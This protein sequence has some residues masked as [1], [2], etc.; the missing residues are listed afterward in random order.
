MAQT[1]WR[2]RCREVV[3]SSGLGYDFVCHVGDIAEFSG[4][5]VINYSE[6]NSL[7]GQVMR[8]GTVRKAEGRACAAGVT[9]DGFYAWRGL[10]RPDGASAARIG[11]L[12]TSRYHAGR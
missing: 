10:R 5:V 9:L 11:L 7:F 8:E 4:P 6:Q 2:D 12:A 3:A 1:A